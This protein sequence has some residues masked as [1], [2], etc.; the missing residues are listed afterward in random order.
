MNREFYAHSGTCADKSDWQLLSDHLQ[1]VAELAADNARYFNGGAMASLAGNLHDLGKYSDAFQ[2]RLEGGLRVDHATA[3]AKVAVEKWGALGKMLAYVIAGHHAGLANGVDEGHGRA[4]LQE[5]L[6][7]DVETLDAIWEDEIDLPDKLILPSFK[8]ANDFEGF[9]L[10]FFTRMLFSCVVD[11]DFIDTE[12]FYQKLNG[13]RA[14]RGSSIVLQ[15]LKNALDEYL[16]NLSIKAL[17]QSTSKVNILRQEIL[18]H[19]RRQAKLEPGLFQLT[20]PT[21]GGKT[22]S[23]MAFA[24][25]HAIQHDL[26]RVIYVIPFT[27][28]IEQNADVFRKVFAELGDEI[29]LE[30]H[31]AFDDEKFQG[32]E[33]TKDKLKLAMENWDAPV[34]V[35]TAVQFFESL[36]ADRTSKC[37][38]LHNITGS[39]IILDEAQ[40]LP[41]KLLRP[42]MAA[43]DELARN[44][45]C[46]I[47][48]CT[49]TQPALLSPD[50]TNGFENVREIAPDPGRLY[51]ELERTVVSHIGEQDDDQ[52]RQQI[53]DNH[54]ILVIVNNRRH[55]RELFCGSSTEDSLFHLTT[56]MCAKHRR[57]I[58]AKAKESLAAGESCKL[59]STSLIEAGVDVSFPLVMRAET[60]LDSVAQAAGRCNREGVWKTEDSKVLVFNAP[61]WKAPPEISQYAASLRHVLRH[62]QGSLLSPEAIKAYFEDVYWQRDDGGL[63]EKGILKAHRDH[64]AKLSFPFQNI[65]R[66]YRIIE[67]QMRPVII[68]YDKQAEEL[69]ESLRHAEFVGKIA[70]GLQ[71][72]LVQVPQRVLDSLKTAGG[73]EAIQPDRFGD[74]F[75]LLINM[76]LY[77]KRT[78]LCWDDP[79]FIKLDRTIM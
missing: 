25:D 30:H 40:M 6:A 64:R 44:Y 29:V 11:A 75:N 37:R 66:D 43:I 12:R 34:V 58:L 52:L 16:E 2:R 73:V 5:R 61:E 62:H 33:E 51:S 57:E 8:P 41:L 39:V 21:G 42:T 32:K 60:G 20:V 45:R 77:G 70:R 13:K 3:G 27:S 53:N 56:L 10:A 76:D 67:S 36:F 74:Q 78:G 49:A 15:Q 68:P 28:I 4:P 63:D 48:L 26:R 19:A 17:Q 14:Q 59:I 22:L 31:S 35:T 23:S 24:L 18:Q 72:Y 65:A 69:A 55:A 38:K 54:Q 71:P 50:F 46:S 9:Q 79:N 7:R 1:K 47:V